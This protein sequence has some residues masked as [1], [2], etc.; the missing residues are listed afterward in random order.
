MSGLPAG[1][2]TPKST[3]DTPKFVSI[4]GTC[5]FNGIVGRSEDGTVLRCTGGHYVPLQ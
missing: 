1:A 4:N 3:S 2:V 5:L